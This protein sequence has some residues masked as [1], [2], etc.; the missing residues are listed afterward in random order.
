MTAT[1]NQPRSDLDPKESLNR[2]RRPPTNAIRQDRV[3]AGGPEDFMEVRHLVL[4][5]TNEEI[6]G[7]LATIAIERF[8]LKAAGQHRLFAHA[9]PAPLHRDELLDP[10]RPHAGCCSCVREAARR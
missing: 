3:I 7:A 10:A 9:R 6:G 8:G 4:T 2:R 5:G 1:R